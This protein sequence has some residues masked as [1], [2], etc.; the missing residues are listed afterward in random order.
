MASVQYEPGQ[1]TGASPR[2]GDAR[3]RRQ[4]PADKGAPPIVAA[5]KHAPVRAAATHTAEER[6]EICPVRPATAAAVAS[7][8]STQV[9]VP[10]IRLRP[11]PATRSGAAPRKMS[12]TPNKRIKKHAAGFASGFATS[13]RVVNRGRNRATAPSVKRPTRMARVSTGRS[14]PITAYSSN[15]PAT[16]RCGFSVSQPGPPVYRCTLSHR[17]Q[18]S[19][20]SAKL[21]RVPVAGSACAG[22]SAPRTTPCPGRWQR[23]RRP[24][25]EVPTARPLVGANLGARSGT[26]IHPTPDASGQVK[27]IAM[28]QLRHGGRLRTHGREG[29]IRRSLWQRARQRNLSSAACRPR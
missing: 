3:P 15:R 22:R 5:L 1:G 6:G 24:V 23:S 19:D 11:G 4:S 26:P 29:R 27:L 16:S 17:R 2:S 14:T 25:V 12:R 8:R 10:R 9:A 20:I 28:P 21:V 7:V 18:W 13:S